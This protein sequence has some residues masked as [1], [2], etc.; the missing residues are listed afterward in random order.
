MNEIPGSLKFLASHNRVGDVQNQL[1]YL[2]PDKTW[3]PVDDLYS[4]NVG[5]KLEKKEL[6][7]IVEKQQNL[8]S[9]FRDA[10][11]AVRSEE[12]RITAAFTKILEC[13]EQRKK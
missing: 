10:V 3:V 8:M 12:N 6:I 11:T 1:H 9:V 13:E 2:M 4:E 5:L 7:R